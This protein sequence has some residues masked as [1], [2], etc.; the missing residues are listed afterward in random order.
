MPYGKQLLDEIIKA[1]DNFVWETAAWEKRDRGP[2]W[3]FIMSAVALAFVV[4]AVA[5]NN[6]LF[7]FLILLCAIIL[8]LAGHE[9]PHAALV[10]I[11]RNG[12]VVDGK[13]YE[14]KAL[15]NFSII[16]HPPETKLLYIETSNVIKPRLR[17]PL[18]EQNPIEIR[19]HLKDFLDENTVLQ[20]EHFSDILARLLK[21]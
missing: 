14:Y 21:I 18:D 2:R 16:Y 10:Q 9:E 8:I 20:E 15:T 7:A 3:Y 11:G 12:V 6:F 13:L 4:Y 19:N 1:Q 5:T 17:I